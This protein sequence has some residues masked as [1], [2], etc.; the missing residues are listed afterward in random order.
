[1]VKGE[2]FNRF[3]FFYYILIS[4]NKASFGCVCPH[5]VLKAARR[6][7]EIEERLE[8]KFCKDFGEEFG[9]KAGEA[10]LISRIH[11]D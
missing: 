8:G 1:M 4:G 3:N 6:I 9:R 2:L 5:K 7:Y 10:I 11:V